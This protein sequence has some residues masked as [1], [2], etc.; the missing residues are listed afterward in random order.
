M[1]G[2]TAVA[3]AP[4]YYAHGEIVPRLAAAAVL[5]VLGGSNAGMR[6]GERLHVRWLKGLMVAVLA[7]VS[8]MMFL[9]LR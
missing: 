6:L 1:I 5:G 2:V 7:I 8:L 9:R 4:I 3:T